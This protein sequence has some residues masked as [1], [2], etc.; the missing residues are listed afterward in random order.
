M[1]RIS[2][3]KLQKRLIRL[4]AVL[5]LLLF[6]TTSFA[7]QVNTMRMWSSPEST[8][9]VFDI[10]APVE[11]SIL[12]LSNPSRIVIDMKN[13]RLSNDAGKLNFRN[14]HIRN[15][16]TATRN[17]SDLRVVLDMKT[18]VNPKS[19]VLPPTQGYGH[20]LVVDLEQ[21]NH[22]PKSRTVQTVKQHTGPKARPVVI[23]IDAGH[24]GEDPGAIGKGGT[25]EK[26]VVL[27]ISRKLR[28]LIR[29]EEGMT[30]VMIR[31]GDYYVSLRGRMKKA[32]EAKADLFISI[33]A[34]A[35]RSG[36]ARGASV[37][38]LSQ[39]GASS[40]AAHWLAA[41]QNESD[42]IGGVSLD[43]KDD[44][45]ASV[46]LDLSQNATLAAST[47]VA[48]NVLKEIKHVGKIHKRH[49]GKAGFMVLKSPDIPSI[50][51]ETGFI[52]NRK[53]EQRLRDKKFQANIA[54]AV[55]KGVRKYF[56]QNPP[57]GTLLALNSQPKPSSVTASSR[58][59]IKRGDTLASIAKRFQVS[60]PSLRSM[61]RL[62]SDVLR[63]GQVLR[64]PAVN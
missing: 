12:T 47:N 15:I 16:R 36:K 56:R 51:V 37:Y 19:F 29:K 55:L 64:V 6:T 61:N 1:V 3:H 5:V 23:A 35:V 33:H 4:L 39:S 42:L 43:D 45:L 49:V 25:H 58:Y 8:R 10:N 63:V 32:R 9:V 27:Q 50:L 31:G 24:G 30:P 13:T 11:H 34:D 52:S 59:K 26:D 2:I 20:R 21:S 62:R 44:M 54:R 40:E 17:R 14:S 53:E 22:R 46:L 48:K 57:P 38:I 60:L 28:D 7:T 18:A 41:S